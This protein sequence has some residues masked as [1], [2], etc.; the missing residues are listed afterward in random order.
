MSDHPNF[1]RVEP[2]ALDEVLADMRAAGVTPTPLNIIARAL[3]LGHP[4][5]FAAVLAAAFRR[6]QVERAM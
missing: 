6:C 5:D 2:G 1:P 3:E 4:G